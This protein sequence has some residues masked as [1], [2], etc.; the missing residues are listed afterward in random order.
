MKP[1]EFEEN[2]HDVLGKVWDVSLFNYSLLFITVL[3]VSVL[4]F[5]ILGFWIYLAPIPAAIV[6]GAIY[7][8][9]GRYQNPV[10]TIEKGSSRAVSGFP[11]SSPKSKTSKKLL[12]VAWAPRGRSLFS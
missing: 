11:R 6:T 4:A 8:F 2:L 5:F 1:D 7:C 10:K 12:S 3:L 9:K